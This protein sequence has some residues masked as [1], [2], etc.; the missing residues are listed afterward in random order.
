[1]KFGESS[2]GQNNYIVQHAPFG[3]MMEADQN[4]F[5]IGYKHSWP[6]RVNIHS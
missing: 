2:T 6:T 3:K 1:M 5:A 4:A